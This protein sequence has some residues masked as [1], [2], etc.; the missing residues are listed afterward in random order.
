MGARFLEL[1]KRAGLTQEEL[2]RE[3]GVTLS[4][5]RQWERG[6]RTPMLDTAVRLAKV[7]GVTVGQLAGT[8]PMPPAKK[9][10]KE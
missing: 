2:A 9:G 6:K 3:A 4:A 5:V 8:E 7:F 10:K 1:R